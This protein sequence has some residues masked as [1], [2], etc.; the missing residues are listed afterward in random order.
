MNEA[1]TIMIVDGYE[2]EIDANL[3]LMM[4][5]LARRRGCDIDFMH[6]FCLYLGLIA[7]GVPLPKNVEI[8]HIKH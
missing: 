5:E 6:K 3:Q 2:F 4:H 7:F 1:N 8:K